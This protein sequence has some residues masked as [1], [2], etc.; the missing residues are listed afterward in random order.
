MNTKNTVKKTSSKLTVISLR[1]MSIVK[2]AN[3]TMEKSIMTMNKKYRNG[4]S[5][6]F[7]NKS[8]L[9]TISRYLVVSN[10]TRH[11]LS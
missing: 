10:K 11:L 6:I 1:V 8:R 5:L 4:E 7:L 3:M 9:T 2:A